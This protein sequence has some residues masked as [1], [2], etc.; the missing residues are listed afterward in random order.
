M[1]VVKSPLTMFVP[2]YSE[3]CW[4]LFQLDRGVIVTTFDSLKPLISEQLIKYSP[5]GHLL[6]QRGKDYLETV[7]NSEL[8]ELHLSSDLL[9]VLSPTFFRALSGTLTYQYPFVED[10]ISAK[11]LVHENRISVTNKGLRY[12]FSCANPNVLINGICLYLGNPQEYNAGAWIKEI[13]FDIWA[14]LLSKLNDKNLRPKEKVLLNA[15][16]EKLTAESPT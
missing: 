16:L 2:A 5:P 7:R 11:L 15:L 13:P 3:A 14:I 4:K 10:L 12:L 9:E 8:E 6:T 1:T